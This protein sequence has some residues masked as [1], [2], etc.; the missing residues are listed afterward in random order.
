ME[1]GELKR[2]PRAGTASQQTAVGHREN[3]LSCTTLLISEGKTSCI[4]LTVSV[5]L[6]WKW[7]FKHLSCPCQD[8]TWSVFAFASK[9]MAPEEYGA[10]GSGSLAEVRLPPGRKVD[11]KSTIFCSHHRAMQKKSLM[12]YLKQESWLSI[13]QKRICHCFIYTLLLS[14]LHLHVCPWVLLNIILQCFSTQ[15]VWC[16]GNTRWSRVKL[17][18]SQYKTKKGAQVS[19]DM[20]VSTGRVIEAQI[21][22]V[23]PSCFQRLTGGWTGREDFTSRERFSPNRHELIPLLQEADGKAILHSSRWAQGFQ[24]GSDSVFGC[25]RDGRWYFFSA[26]GSVPVYESYPWGS[27]LVKIYKRGD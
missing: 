15:P 21:W 16:S 18:G 26:M 4:Y 25:Y 17:V 11:S 14:I 20:G 9:S 27:L 22:Q 5:R 7:P 12:G 19:W 24:T 3:V 13:D 2:I 1:R 23:F 10:F 8:W 6:T